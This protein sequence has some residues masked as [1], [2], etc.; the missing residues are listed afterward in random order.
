MSF[1]DLHRVYFIGIGGIGMSG[2]ARYFKAMGITVAGY[3][4]T[5][6]I[7]CESLEKEGITI[8]YNEALEELPSEFLNQEQTLV[9][10][11]PAVPEKHIQLSY[12]KAQG[13]VV[14]KRAKVLGLITAENFSLA[15]A[16]THG[17]T[18]TSC[19]LAHLLKHSGMQINAFLGG[20]ALN[21]Q[22]NV[23]LGKEKIVV[24]E[25]DEFDRSFLHLKPNLALITN[26][27]ADHLDIYGSEQEFVKGFEDFAQICL[28]QGVLVKQKDVALEATHTYGLDKGAD[29]FA[30]N[31]EVNQGAYKFDLQLLEKHIGGLRLSLPGRHNIENAVGAAALAYLKGLSAEQIRDGI[32]SF[33][34]VYRRFQYHIQTSDLV[35]IDDYAH[36]PSEIKATLKS[37]RELFP[38]RKITVVFQPH[39]FSRTRDFMQEFGQSLSMADEVILLPIYPAREAPLEGISSEVLLEKVNATNKEVISYNELVS[40][41]SQKT[42]D[43]LLTLGAGDIDQLVYPIANVLKMNAS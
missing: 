39:L 20:L 41:L 11:T 2:L 6:T 18:T 42:I 15:V 26:T 16:G 9:V 5:R 17:K 7:L 33:S 32:N 3:D 37:A 43:V 38:G 30:L 27:D 21:Y 28:L 23:L 35:Y 13:F 24:V 12:F 31:I 4:R 29:F 8:N 36:H 25:A 34:G 1:E 14:M 19:I 22:S 10:Y 40:S